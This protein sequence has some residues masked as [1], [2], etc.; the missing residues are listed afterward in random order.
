MFWQI[1]EGDLGAGGGEDEREWLVPNEGEVGG[2]TAPE[3]HA[4]APAAPIAANEPQPPAQ[5][6]QG[7]ST[8]HER[9]D[10][11]DDHIDPVRLATARERAEREHQRLT[12]SARVPSFLD[13]YLDTYLA[14]VNALPLGER[15]AWARGRRG[16]HKQDAIAEALC[17]FVS[18]HEMPPAVEEW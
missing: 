17:L 12:V 15:P 5:A 13:R 6:A 7:A 3:S 18:A 8:R 9:P 4:A 10:L 11:P 2:D 14:R 1:V 16:V